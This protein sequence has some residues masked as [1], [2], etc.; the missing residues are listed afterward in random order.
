ML[1]GHDFNVPSGMPR[2]Q[3]KLGK[4]PN[5]F[6][7][8]EKERLSIKSELSR[9]KTEKMSACA[10][11][12]STL[13]TRR[14]LEEINGEDSKVP[15]SV[16]EEIP[17][18]ARAVNLI[19]GRLASSNGSRLFDVGAG[20]SG[21]LGVLDAA[22]L[23]PTY[24]VGPEKVRA[25]IAGG[26]DAIFA[27]VEGAED[28]QENA[29]RDLREANFSKDDIL[30]GISA[31]GRTPY[32]IGAMTYAR[33]LGASTIGLTVNSNSLLKSYADITICPDTGPEVVAGSTRM[34]AGT[35]QKLILNM[36]STTVM[37]KLGKVHGNLMVNLRPFSGKLRERQKRILMAETGITYRKAERKLAEA[38]GDLGLA[39]VMTKLGI[40]RERAREILEDSGGSIER[41]L[42]V[43]PKA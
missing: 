2:E 33:K 30:V 21:R 29:V 1:E 3:L 12:L 15:K 32:V 36:I 26:R 41:A 24:G 25:I 40:D 11:P 14:I 28:S 37:I 6:S 22:E 5:W 35:A 38:R 19:A 20:T 43:V 17:N 27:P 13:S 34:K 7:V 16:A 18:I 39:I 8:V 4:N 9:L 23:I 31:S 42:R 10:L